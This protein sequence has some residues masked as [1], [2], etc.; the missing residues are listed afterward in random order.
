LGCSRAVITRVTEVGE[1]VHAVAANGTL[2]AITTVLVALI[3]AH[4]AD[5]LEV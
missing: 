4:R 3:E 1:S 5:Q 2:V